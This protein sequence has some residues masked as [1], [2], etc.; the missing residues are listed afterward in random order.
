GQVLRYD[1][2]NYTPGFVAMTDLR[3]KVTGTT[4]FASSC[5]SNQTLTYSSVADTMS[6]TNIAIAS[7]QVSGLGALATKSAIDLS[8]TDA[9]GTLAAGRFP[10]HTGDVTT[11]A[12]SLTTTIANNVVSN[13]KFRQGVARSVVGVT[14]NATANVAD[15]QGT[16]NQVL[17]VNSTG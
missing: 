16:A 5:G 8:T 6:C 12:G 11:T 9:T 14:G 4:A 10:A 7:T 3:S 13:A 2:T 15:I 17:R 1:G